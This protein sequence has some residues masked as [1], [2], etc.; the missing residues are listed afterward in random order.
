MKH[1]HT[2]ALLA[3][4]IVGVSAQMD[5]LQERDAL[6]SGLD[7]VTEY[8]DDCSTVPTTS[9]TPCSSAGCTN[10]VVTG[11]F[12]VTD[13]QTITSC[14]KCHSDSSSGSSSTLGGSA[15]SSPDVT[16]TNT[17]TMTHCPGPSCT[18]SGHLTPH[19]GGFTTTYETVYSIFCPTGLTDQTY[20]LTQTYAQKPTNSDAVPTGL[21]SGFTV[22]VT[23]CTHCGPTP[24]TATLT[25]CTICHE[26]GG[27]N[28][29]ATGVN[30]PTSSPA[31]PS[32]T[33]LIGAYLSNSATVSNVVGGASALN[34]SSSTASESTGAAQGIPAGSA[35]SPSS[36]VSAGDNNNSHNGDGVG[37][38]PSVSTSVAASSSANAGGNPGVNPGV[39]PGGNPG[40]DP[41]GNG[42][43]GSGSSSPKAYTGSASTLA[44][45]VIWGGILAFILGVAFWL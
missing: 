9:S 13:T 19:S 40:G 12:S 45:N 1:L 25:V 17:R 42:T 33:G 22:T 11:T 23:A 24:I 16:I 3:V 29:P 18:G 2:A 27:G 31:A 21:P 38:L 34:A 43:P 37:Q 28:G 5:V 20:T 14:T 32:V 41:G 15:S 44:A 39:N 7:Y 26:N 6:A 30:V 10:S 36:A 35:S 8:Y 4:T